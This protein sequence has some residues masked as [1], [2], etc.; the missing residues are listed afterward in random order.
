MSKVKVNGNENV[1][2][3][4]VIG[5][6]FCNISLLHSLAAEM[7]VTANTGPRVVLPQLWTRGIQASLVRRSQ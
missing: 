4:I 1:D 2:I 7:T 5:S 3:V 6:H